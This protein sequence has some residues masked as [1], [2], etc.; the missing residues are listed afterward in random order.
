MKPMTTTMEQEM[1]FLQNIFGS[2]EDTDNLIG[3]EVVVTEATDFFGKG[4]VGKVVHVDR[5]GAL[6]VDYLDDRNKSS[7]TPS[8]SGVKLDNVVVQHPL[9]GAAIWSTPIDKV[10]IVE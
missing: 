3:K 2:S 8:I 7:D 4:C 6:W 9:T 5:R 1:S 10:E